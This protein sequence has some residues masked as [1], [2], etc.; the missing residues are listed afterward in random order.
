MLSIYIRNFYSHYG[1]RFKF[2]EDE[3]NIFDFIVSLASVLAS[4]G[5]AVFRVIRM[6][7]AA[8]I[9]EFLPY[10]KI[11]IKSVVNTIQLLLYVFIALSV[12][13]LYFIISVND[14][15]GAVQLNI[16]VALGRIFTL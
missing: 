4:S 11:I 12:V 3:W 13:F 5:V 16:L 14:M 9:L 8:E 6:F 1:R 15:F 10:I 7:R 2:L